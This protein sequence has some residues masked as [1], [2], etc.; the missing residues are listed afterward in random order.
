M[1]ENALLS[2]RDLVIEVATPS[3]PLPVVDGVSFAL[4]RGEVLSIVGES[5]SG[6]SITMLALM[7]LLDPQSARVKSG[8]IEFRGAA[9][10]LGTPAMD[11]L[12]GAALAMIF[13]EPM[14]S[15]NPVLT[16]GR[17]IGESVK[18]HQPQLAADAVRRRTVELLDLVGVPEPARR[19][20]Q[21]PHEYSGGM[22]QRVMIAMAIANHPDLLIA[23]E[24]TTALDVTIQAQVMDVLARIRE[25][26]GAAMILVTHDLG[27]VA[28]NADRVAVMYAGH[29]VETASCEAIFAQPRHPYTLGLL[30]S[31]P[32]ADVTAEELSAIP[33]QPP[34][35]QDRPAGCVFHPRCA[36]RREREICAIESPPLAA[37]APEHAVACH[38]ADETALAPE[39]ALA[40]EQV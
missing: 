20:R 24:P 38:F 10:P 40:R 18:A 33:G 12:R 16:V 9:L 23:D 3:G 30:A 26:S 29:L 31:L 6:K 11:A 37:I 1:A 27:L 13:Q 5:G 8:Q 34:G 7:G 17:Q 22:R 4:A 36:L 14:T 35:V 25:E 28:E 15:L 39:R 2:V 19:M 32:R 21:Y